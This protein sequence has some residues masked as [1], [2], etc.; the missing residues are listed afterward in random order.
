MFL[1]LKDEEIAAVLGILK[2]VVQ[3]DLIYAKAWIRREVDR[4]LSTSLNQTALRSDAHES[5]DIL[6]EL[7]AIH[8]PS[9]KDI[10]LLLQSADKDVDRLDSPN[11]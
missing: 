8:G 1:G 2:P 10:E 7:R 9:L 11:N 6:A 5:L 3:R 4:I